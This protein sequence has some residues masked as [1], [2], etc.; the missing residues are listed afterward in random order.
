MKKDYCFCNQFYFKIV[1]TNKFISVKLKFMT[2]LLI[3][4]FLLRKQFKIQITRN[5]KHL[6]LVLIAML[7]SFSATPQVTADFTTINSTQGCGSLVAEFKDLSLGNPT[8]WLWDFG[9]GNT[10][11]LKNPIAVYNAPGVY[12]VTITVSDGLSTD[13]KTLVSYIHV[14]EE[15]VAIIEINS[16]SNGCMP[17]NSEF[18]DASTTNTS[19]IS[20][21]WDFG[22]GG[23]SNFQNPDYTY[24]SDGLYS[25]SLSVVDI[26][27]CQDLVTEID[28]V[29]VDILP[30]SDFNADITFSC[31]SLELV[32]FSN[33]TISASSFFW[34]FGDGTTSTLSNPNHM[35]SQ[36]LFTVSLYS[37]NASC[38]DTLVLT[39]LIEVAGVFSPEFSFSSSSGCKGLGVY[40]SDLTSN[41]PNEF[42]WDFGDGIISTSQNPVHIFDSVGVYDISLTT[43]ISGN[44][45]TKFTLPSA[46]EIFPIPVISFYS[47]TTLG[48]SAPFEV[49]FY[50]NSSGATIWNWDFG[51]GNYSQL[52][53]PLNT[54]NNAGLFNV[55]LLVENSYGCVTSDT[56][57]NYIKI[58]EL[59]VVDLNANPLVSCVGQDISFTDL[60][61]FGSNDWNWY[62]GDDSTSNNQHPTHQ[63][64]IPGIY[65]VRLI[66]GVDLC[67][68]TLVMFDYIEIIEPA[69][70]FEEIYSCENPL[71]VEFNSLS[72]GADNIFWDF[73][74]GT[75]STLINPMHTFSSLGFHSVSLSVSNSL[76][77]CTH[78]LSKQIQLT[79][80]V[81]EFD[82]LINSNNGYEDSVGC[83]PKR[84]YLDQKSQ[85]WDWYKVLWSDGYVGSSR[86]DH[87]FTDS[88]VFDVTMIVTD[89][90]DCK[91][92]ATIDN[93]FHMYDVNLD[94]KISNILGCDSM[95]VEFEDLSNHTFTSIKWDFGDGGN[96]TSSNPQY[97]YYNEGV[98]DVSLYTHSIYGC[99]DTL[100][101]IDYVNFE[102]VEADFTTNMQN[103][104]HDEQVHFFNHS[105][106]VGISS[107]WDF[108]DGTSSYLLDPEHVFLAN[109]LYDITLLVVDS[110]GCS[111]SMMLI[112]YIEVF[113][114]E[115]NFS[116]LP[117]TTNCAPVISDFINL[118]S[119]DANIFLW[120]FG[121]G[122]FS[123]V[124]NPSHLFSSSGLFDISLIVENAFGCKDTL[125][126]SGYINMSG[127]MPE[128]S[129]M[130]S[131]TLVCKN[132]IVSFFPTVLNTNSFLWDF[133]N[134]MIS[135]DS[136]ATISYNSAGVFSPSL[137]IEN[138]S[139]C[140]LTLNSDYSI[141]VN[142]VFVDAG[143]DSEICE[144][145]SIELTATGN[146]MMFSWTPVNT[147]SSPHTSIS[148]ASPIVSGFYYVTSTDGMCTAV[149]SVFIIV[150][151]DV[152]NT[153]FSTNGLC[154]G[155]STSFVANSG[156]NTNNNSYV[157]SFGESGKAVSSILNLGINNVV[158]IIENL[159]NSCSDTLEKNVIV[160]PNPIAD[161]FVTEVCFGE[162]SS[163]S[164]N[165]SNDV[166]AWSYN[167]GD[168]I[169]ISSDSNSSYT[170]LNAGLY[171]VSL[172]VISNLGCENNILK[173]VIVRDIPVATVNTNTQEICEGDHVQFTNIS[174]SNLANLTWDFG[175]GTLSNMI[176][177]NHI[178]LVNG[179]YDINLLYVDSFGCSDSLF[180]DDYIEVL[181]PEADFYNLPLASNCAPVSVDFIN[182][183]SNDASLFQWNFGDG[184]SSVLDNPSHLFSDSGLFEISLIVENLFGCTDTLV[185]EVELLANPVADF[186]ISDICLGDSVTFF[187]N[188]SSDAV[189]WSYDF[190]DGT[191]TSSS[192]NPAY[193]YT[194]SGVYHVSLSIIS[195]MGCEDSVIKDLTVHSLPIAD[196]SIENN[197]EGEGNIFTDLS[198][199]EDG[200]IGLIRYDFN[201]GTT[202]TDSIVSHVFNGYG[203]FDVELTATSVFG[204]S[205][206]IIKNT[207]VFPNPIVDFSALQ[208]CKG[209]E[210]MFQSLSYVPDADIVLYSWSFGLEEFSDSA[211]ATHIFSDYGV[212]DVDLLV[213]SDNGCQGSFN[214]EIVINKLPSLNFQFSSDVCLGDEVEFLYNTELNDVNISK[215]NYDFGDG[216]FSGDQSPLYNYNY[217]GTFDIGLEVVSVEGCKNDTII[218]AGIV[219]HNFP[220]VD[221]KTSTLFASE[222]S[223][224][225]NFY[226]Y[227]LGATFFEWDFDNGDYSFEENPVF[228]FDDPQIYNVSLMATNNA[229]CSSEMIKSIHIY[230]E[231]TFFI[232]DAFSPNGDGVNDVFLAQGN[233]VLSFEM[234]VFDRWGGIVFESSNINL[235]WDGKTSSGDDLSSGTYLFHIA[236]YDINERPWVYN[237][238][239]KLIR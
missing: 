159:D 69:A 155:D 51:N 77:G 160:S 234:Q 229:G 70:V 122:N 50:D 132:D 9:N 203:L 58:H 14:H 66:A 88:G 204:C 67:Q 26:N 81:A 194:N 20:W 16:V 239:L 95:L 116:N 191:G 201:D 211:F 217:A 183:S 27:G 131:D 188:S 208:F 45:V 138:S 163:F 25:V 119:S 153:N 175:D 44:C 214:R 100:Q 147:L 150:H 193:I 121:D 97:V 134:G 43:S 213:L 34:D 216:N 32:S 49:M 120:D 13:V 30:I 169:G 64:S 141:V 161:F 227:S 11:N 60:S 151:N 72:I 215:W 47:D 130:P 165:S 135:T 111:D 19:I 114:P 23:S 6:F 17:L 8:T 209:E 104:C 118:S 156:L 125:I 108:G 123:T 235:G 212:Y 200:A 158:L 84:V 146:S 65:D 24:I 89:I 173:D 39:D 143:I 185:K 174:N 15:P 91:D 101:R 7:V 31:D 22:D 202:S 109:G 75:T 219:V 90:H 98:Y 178:F 144:G 74:D 221:F 182:L 41:S 133:G 38:I 222:L 18:E 42:L 136:I 170:Y 181:S 225:I 179:L 206:T 230:P 115:A 220:V 117:L 3:I 92:T 79:Q 62:F 145:E 28:F 210:T 52:Q 228:K 127:L 232:P 233:R 237:G 68:D 76:T 142:D 5:Y 96:S 33:N 195:N 86:I 57:P 99:K 1:I 180:L 110:F 149:D 54:Y 105:A 126:E 29:E 176:H 205:T 10:S 83:I 226:N 199:L 106:G 113:S 21:Q 166:V 102:H 87:L 46:I 186:L 148:L 196:F 162:L 168:S 190:A 82:Y 192:Q 85:D 172:N 2:T 93:M 63:Y 12:N 140:Q 198:L 152:P 189:L 35:F 231:H 73:G 177:P 137:I 36:G 197:C 61:S 40:F 94:F 48:C 207:E 171:N 154:F 236:L 59:P 78:V 103:V 53:N 55:S 112:N 167:F 184:Y 128:G 71:K 223:S 124:E 187:N 224:E 37:Y 139:G 4:R 80:P 164:D 238:E 56:F 157:W 107:I 129:F 218:P